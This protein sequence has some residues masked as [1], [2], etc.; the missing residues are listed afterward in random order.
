MLPKLTTPVYTI[1]LP[2]KQEE[3]KFR[4][5]LVKEQK[6]LLLA[7]ESEDRSFINNNIKEVLKN[8]C[9]SDI[10]IDELS[11]VDI[12]YFF[13]QLR[14]RSIGEIVES[15]YRCENLV[16][17]E[18]T[19]ELIPCKNLMPVNLD[20]LKIKVDTSNY[21]DTIQ[22]TGEVGIKFKYPTYKTLEK[23]NSDKN[24]IE[25]TFETIIDCIDYIFDENNFYYPKELSKKEL[26]EFIESL[27]IQTYKK[28]EE[29]FKNLPK[30]KEDISIKCD[31]C[32]FE[33]HIHLEGLESFLD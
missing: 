31:K 20:L 10:N 26:Q 22:I 18:D 8:C 24:I 29:Y 25:K 9:L 5:F 13:L 12:E 3:I 28:I 21:K 7:M 16:E 14:A 2:I 1:V 23:L 11:A 27:D 4:P 6:I 30:L 33:H 32:G 15:R 19:E 17:D